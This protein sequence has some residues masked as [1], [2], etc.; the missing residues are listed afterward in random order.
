MS[1]R[2]GSK[3]LFEGGKISVNKSTV[4]YNLTFMT[5]SV[6]M[7]TNHL[8]VN[9]FLKKECGQKNNKRSDMKMLKVT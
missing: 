6:F 7:K 9:Y 1:N 2:K 5:F 3:S 4:T 8:G